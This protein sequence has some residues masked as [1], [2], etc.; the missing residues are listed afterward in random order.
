MKT[1]LIFKRIII[2]NDD[3][4]RTE[5]KVVPV[6]IPN[7]DFSQGWTLASC[8]DSIE[9][10]EWVEPKQNTESEIAILTPMED[11]DKTEIST[12]I[13][14]CKKFQSSVPGTARLVRFGG[15]ILITRR[16]GSTTKNQ[17]DSNSICIS[18]STKQAFFDDVRRLR[19]NNTA[20][21][22]FYQTDVKYYNYWNLWMNQEYE[23]QLNDYKKSI[24]ELS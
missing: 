13:S 6:E 5:M 15:K 10:V 16:K 19:G 23:K 3:E 17:T 7:I 14:E 1:N 9:I 12:S 4:R 21:F 11:P 22:A 2:S 20:D 18:D 8:C 24:Q